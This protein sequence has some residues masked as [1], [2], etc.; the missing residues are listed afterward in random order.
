M[1]ILQDT[2]KLK[3]GETIEKSDFGMYISIDSI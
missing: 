1:C 2:N 3:E